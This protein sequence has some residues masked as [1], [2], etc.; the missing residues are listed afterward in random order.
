MII[1]LV[2]QW[3]GYDHCWGKGVRFN[4]T[5]ATTGSNKEDIKL[6]NKSEENAIR[7]ENIVRKYLNINEREYD[8]YPL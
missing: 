5:K 3:S 6:G 1:L 2:L 8:Y 4:R 7:K